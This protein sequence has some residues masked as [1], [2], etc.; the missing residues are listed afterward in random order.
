MEWLQGVDLNRE[1]LYQMSWPS[2]W[3]SPMGNPGKHG[4]D[5]NVLLNLQI[6]SYLYYVCVSASLCFI[7]FAN[8]FNIFCGPHGS[9]KDL[10]KTI[11]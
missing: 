4:G 3:K 2:Q 8:L 11:S 5:M 7:Y 9:F 6:L 10:R 1:C